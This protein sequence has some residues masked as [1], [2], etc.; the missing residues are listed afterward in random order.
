MRG[1]GKRFGSARKCQKSIYHI[2]CEFNP[3]CIKII[4]TLS[5]I[6]KKK[7]GCPLKRKLHYCVWPVWTL[8]P[9]LKPGL[10]LGA[11]DALQSDFN[12]KPKG[13]TVLHTDDGFLPRLP[14]LPGVHQIPME[15]CLQELCA[16][17][18]QDYV[19]SRCFFF[20][21]ST[22]FV[23]S[24]SCENVEIERNVSQDNYHL[25]KSGQASFL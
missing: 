1:F 21:H 3:W 12:A 25:H 7:K 22:Q 20:I 9:H 4:A 16:T 15:M 19:F 13:E 2:K 8:W 10:P 11:V 6:S 5:I 14:Q 24:K 17:K 18:H 23:F